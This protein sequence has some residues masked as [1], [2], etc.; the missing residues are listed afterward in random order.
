MLRA[1]GVK[2]TKGTH[3]PERYCTLDSAVAETG[4]LN[5]SLLEPPRKDGDGTSV[6]GTTTLADVTGMTAVWVFERVAI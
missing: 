2:W 5:V 1:N 6:V 4:K 3:F